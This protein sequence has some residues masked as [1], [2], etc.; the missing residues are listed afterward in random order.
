[1]GTQVTV[2]LPDDGPA[3]ADREVVALFAEWEQTLSRFLPGS[4]LSRLNAAAGDEV[5]VGDLLFDV[6]S[7]A[8]A[9]AEA[10]GGVFDPTLLH[11]LV[12]Q[13]YDRSFERVPATR[14][15]GDPGALRANATRPAATPPA[16]AR[17]AGRWN[18]VRLQ[19][20]LRSITLPAGV[21]LDLGGIAKGMAVDA[22]VGRLRAAGIQAMVVEAGGDLAVHGT[23][24]GGSWPIAVETGTRT[25]DVELDRGALAT[26]SIGKRRW[27]VDGEVRHHLIDPR[28]GRPAATDLLSVT[29]AAGTCR[30]AEV[31]A[32]CALILGEAQ[33]GAF[34]QRLGLSGILVTGPGPDGAAGSERVI[35][36]G[37]W[38]STRDVA[39]RGTAA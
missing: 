6:A 8:L 11:Q 5:L 14:A 32:K 17:P 31:A 2:L 39:A 29:V 3:G 22:A 25:T 37:G 38:A 1:M 16:A 28:A 12:A 24:A 15:A 30:E 36:I 4:E 21:G 10:T 34:L 18:H 19:P 7:A 20:R 23:P 13:G 27:T 26:S 9:A 33:G 35:P